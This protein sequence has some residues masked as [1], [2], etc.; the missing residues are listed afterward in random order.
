MI[1]LAIITISGCSKSE[2]PLGENTQIEN[3]NGNNSSQSTA[4]YVDLGLP[5]G[6]KW[7]SENE[8]HDN[9]ISRELF[10]YYDA[11]AA[12]GDKLPTEEQ[13]NELIS[14]CRWTKYDDF[15]KIVGP[16]GNFITINKTNYAPCEGGYTADGNSYFWSSTPNGSTVYYLFVKFRTNQ[17]VIRYNSKCNYFAVRLVQK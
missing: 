10:T 8:Q 1:A 9:K 4:T 11:V 15:Y 7:K 6:T 16:N 2:S 3:N 5:S 14:M 17:K 13:F 12:Y